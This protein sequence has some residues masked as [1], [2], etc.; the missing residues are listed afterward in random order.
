[1]ISKEIIGKVKYIVHKVKVFNQLNKNNRLNHNMFVK[2]NKAKVN[3][4]IEIINPYAASPSSGHL[5]FTSS[6]TKYD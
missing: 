4:P 6:L 3:N 5:I 2:P 1:M